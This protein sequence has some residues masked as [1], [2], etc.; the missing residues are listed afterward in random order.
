MNSVLTTLEALGLR[1]RIG[2]GGRLQV[3]P[4]ERL[5]DEVRELVRARADELRVEL[6]GDPASTA[7]YAES[8][9]RAIAATHGIRWSACVEWLTPEDVEAAIPYVLAAEAGDEAEA[10]GLVVWLSLLADPHTPKVPRT[11]TPMT[12]I[13]G[14]C[15][16]ATPEH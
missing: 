9:L 16:H 15:T 1:A 5:T 6:T 11:E 2:P 4:R 10:R 8:R 13:N 12:T 7:S 14:G 3:G